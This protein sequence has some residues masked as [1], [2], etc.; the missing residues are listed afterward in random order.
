MGWT[1]A[2]YIRLVWATGHW[3]M[4]NSEVLAQ[5]RREGRACIVCFWHGRLLMMPCVWDREK[6]FHMLISQHADGQIIARTVGHF[7]IETIEGSTTR[8]GSGAVRSI[9]RALKQGGWVGVTP[10]GPR[11]PRMRATNGAI[12][13]ARLSGVPIIPAAISAKRS[14]ILESWDRFM[15][16]LPFGGGSVVWGEPLEVQRDLPEGEVEPMRRELE[17]RLNAVTEQADRLCGHT[18]VEPAPVAVEQQ[19]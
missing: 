11:G 17:L 19:P 12:D 18:P 7:G 3:Q 5:I 13:M 9:L 6:S 4:V 1:G 14:R 15:I 8:G 2:Q 16:A 10:D